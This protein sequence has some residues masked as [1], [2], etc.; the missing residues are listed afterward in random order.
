MMNLDPFR[1]EIGSVWY[2]APDGSGLKFGKKIPERPFKMA[3]GP[4]TV[5]QS[6]SP[7]F[8]ATHQVVKVT[9]TPKRFG[10][11]P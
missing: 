5:M 3:F 11:Y 2:N 1:R 7:P 6:C 10:F 9:A 4:A 8:A